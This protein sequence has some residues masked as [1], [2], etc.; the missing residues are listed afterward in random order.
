MKTAELTAA[1][2]QYIFKAFAQVRF[3]QQIGIELDEIRR[4]FATLHLDIRNDL[5]QNSGLVHGGVIASLIDT[6]AAFAVMTHLAPEQTAATV[7]LT[8][9]YLRPLTTGRLIARARVLQAGRRLVTSS[10]EVFNETENFVAAA[11]TT[12]T[13]RP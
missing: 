6:A 3:A 5:K 7:D 10:V 2:Q 1:E 11:L 12:F 13:R 8:I 4:G 9:H